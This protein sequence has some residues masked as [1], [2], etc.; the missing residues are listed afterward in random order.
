LGLGDFVLVRL[1][2][3]D[4]CPMWMGRIESEVVKDEEFDNFG[5]VHIQCWVPMRKRAR[6][7]R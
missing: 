7:D 6:N 2:D 1:V 4:L 5:H 3:L